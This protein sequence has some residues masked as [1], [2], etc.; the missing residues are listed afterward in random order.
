MGY[1]ATLNDINSGEPET[2][3]SVKTNP[4]N[5]KGSGCKH[6]LKVLFTTE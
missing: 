5:T 6:V 3:P 2:I 1:F 4:K